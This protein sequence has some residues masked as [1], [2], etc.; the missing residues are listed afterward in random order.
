MIFNAQGLILRSIKY[1]E[2]SQII[3]VYT[4]DYGKQSFIVNGVR[5]SRPRFSSACTQP[6]NFVSLEAYGPISKN[7]KRVKE[8]SLLHFYKTIPFNPI[9][10]V[11]G[12]FILE[13]FQ[14]CISEP[15]P[16]EKLYHFIYNTLTLIDQPDQE[17]KH[18]AIH[19]LIH[20]ATHLGI[21]PIPIL[22]ERTHEGIYSNPEEIVLTEEVY[23]YFL[24]LTKNIE[25]ST[26]SVQPISKEN[27]SFLFNALINHFE[28]NIPKFGKLK[29]L[30]VINSI[31]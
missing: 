6:L 5:K 8:I 4:L 21:G 28:Y 20:F 22:K 11:L 1:K 25:I 7:I 14:K 30:N 10:S 24:V 26:I 18:I 23:Q 19:F 29:S 27:R 3:D 16:D 17:L 2:S 12:L 15:E 9:K 31:F 13:A